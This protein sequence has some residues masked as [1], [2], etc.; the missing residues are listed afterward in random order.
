MKNKNSNVSAFYAGDIV[1]QG[2][3][4][5]SAGS[6]T[7][8]LGGV[9]VVNEVVKEGEGGNI[10]ATENDSERTVSA[11]PFSLKSAN[12]PGIT[13]ERIPNFFDPYVTGIAVRP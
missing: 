8:T 2:S 1:E 12:R 5:G 10:I 7:L 3:E 13:F 6:S 9:S 11:V 4:Q